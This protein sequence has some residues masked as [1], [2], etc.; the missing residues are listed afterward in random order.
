S[1]RRLGADVSLSVRRT[2]CGRR[3]GRP[4]DGWSVWRRLE[5]RRS[6]LRRGSESA[7]N[8]RKLRLRLWAAR[9]PETAHAARLAESSRL[10]RHSRT[11]EA[12]LSL[13]PNALALRTNS[14]AGPHKLLTSEASLPARR[15]V[16]EGPLVVV[17]HVVVAPD[18]R[19][20][21]LRRHP[22]NPHCRLRPGRAATDGAA[23]RWLSESSGLLHSE[24]ALTS[25]PTL[26]AEAA[27]R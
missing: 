23:G 27:L 24:T 20:L 22:L 26:R 2:S 9:L 12:P 19:L 11:T 6:R 7:R 4:A 3:V 17:V 13:R 5:R 25:E 14:L 16:D 8:R 1:G 10:L 15:K 18:R 21:A